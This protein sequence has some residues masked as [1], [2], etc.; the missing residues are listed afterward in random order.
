MNTGSCGILL[1]RLFGDK[2]ESTRQERRQ[3]PLG[4]GQRREN[5]EFPV[6][7]SP[8]KFWLRPLQHSTPA[9]YC[10]IFAGGICRSQAAPRATEK[11]S[12]GSRALQLVVDAMCSVIRGGVFTPCLVGRE[13]MWGC[14]RGAGGHRFSLG[15]VSQ[16]RGA[17]SRCRGRNAPRCCS[18]RHS[19]PTWLLSERTQSSRV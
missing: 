2:Q 17:L 15:F 1:L 11:P 6:P 4:Q 3:R 16:D 8:F 13:W 5:N 10:R 14:G 18:S 19:C 12:Y 7:E 9:R